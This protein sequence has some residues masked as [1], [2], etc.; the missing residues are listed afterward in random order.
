MSFYRVGGLLFAG[1]LFA[2]KQSTMSAAQEFLGNPDAQG[3]LLRILVRE[4][5]A[6]EARVIES[7]KKIHDLEEI[8]RYTHNQVERLDGYSQE[9]EGRMASMEVVI[10]NLLNGTAAD[11][12]I[13]VV[14]NIRA[15][16]EYEMCDLDRLL[17]E[18]ETDDE[19]EWFD[20][21]WTL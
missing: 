20:E 2:I 4:L 9:L 14:H 15:T 6:A 13:D 16:R 3:V 21:M 11:A 1:S 8:A 12:V 10:G 17:E 19:M 7:E 5:Q 18:F